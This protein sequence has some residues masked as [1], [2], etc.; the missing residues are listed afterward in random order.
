MDLPAELRV[1]ILE[2][3]LPARKTYF[4]SPEGKHTCISKESSTFKETN[5]SAIS[6]PCANPHHLAV[7]L[8]SKQVFREAVPIAG[9]RNTVFIDELDSLERLLNPSDSMLKY[10]RHLQLRL[11][12]S[13]HTTIPTG[14]LE[15][16]KRL[17]QLRSISINH[18]LICQPIRNDGRTIWNIKLLDPEGYIEALA[19]KL[20]PIVRKQCELSRLTAFQDVVYVTVESTRCCLVGGKSRSEHCVELEDKIYTRFAEKRGLEKEKKAKTNELNN[21]GQEGVSDA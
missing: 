4:R 6:I 10:V 20:W 3:A 1:R 13:L 12:G 21:D 14:T 9:E 7:L 19:D 8:A 16:M 18:S 2:M 17:L 11:I 15:R 5:P